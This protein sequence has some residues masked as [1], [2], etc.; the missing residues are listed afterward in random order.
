[1]V[2]YDV[3][4]L[5]FA[6]TLPCRRER[7]KPKG[8]RILNLARLRGAGRGKVVKGAA[9]LRFTKKGK[10]VTFSNMWGRGEMANAQ[11]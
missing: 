3:I 6:P 7:R 4:D 8:P 5:A 1:M 11:D 2:N 9:T 10:L